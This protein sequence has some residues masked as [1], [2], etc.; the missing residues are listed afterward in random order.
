[1]SF[2]SV[3]SKA[4]SNKITKNIDS[5]KQELRTYI[6]QRKKNISETQK[7]I[8][9]QKVFDKIEKLVEF[10]NA[11][12]ILL[13]WSMPDELPTHNFIVKWCK[14]K[15]ILLPIVKGDTMLIKPFLSENELK[16][17]NYGVWEPSSQTEFA[18]SIDMV[19]APGIAFDKNRNRLGRGKGYYDRFFIK[20]DLTKIGIGFDF[21]LFDKVPTNQYDIKLDKIITPSSTIE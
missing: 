20:S 9:A 3:L 17:S 16:K 5:E 6:K 21:Q 4:F 14:Q 8:D 13:Y 11:K 18:N 1:M 10:E 15:E 12:T 19:I 2:I 7:S